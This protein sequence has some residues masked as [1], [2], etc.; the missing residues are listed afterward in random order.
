MTAKLIDGRAPDRRR[1][2]YHKTRKP[3]SQVPQSSDTWAEVLTQVE[4]GDREGRLPAFVKDEFEAY[5]A[6][7]LLSRGCLHVRCEWCGDEM[8]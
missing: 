6:C 8:D 4:A 5:V 3:L 7:G 2:H 1:R